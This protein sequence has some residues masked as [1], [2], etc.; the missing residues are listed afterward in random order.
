MP[1]IRRVAHARS[2]AALVCAAALLGAGGAGAQPV[3]AGERARLLA[4]GVVETAVVDALDRADRV[5]VLVVLEG[6]QYETGALAR[7]AAGEDRVRR[8]YGGL[9]A[10][11]VEISGPGLARLA[12]AP[13]VVRV[14]PD[15]RVEA[16]LAQGVPLANLHWL[17]NQGVTG[18]GATVA[19]LDTGIDSDHPN[20]A[21][22]IVAQRCFCDLVPGAGCC[23]NGTATQS[24]AGAAEDDH[25]HG[26]RVA[27]VIRS[28]HASAWGGAPDSS[29]VAVKVLDATGNGMA[30][31][32]LA[33]LDWIL[34]DR[35]DVDVVNM[36]LG[37]GVYAGDCDDAD[38]TTMAFADAVAP[39]HA[40]GTLVVAGSG[41]NNHANAMIMP[42]CVAQVLSVGAV[43][44]ADLGSQTHFVCTDSTTQADQITCWSNQSTT[45]DV[46]APGALTTTTNRGGGLATV[47]GTSYAT[48]LA[49]ACAAALLS[50][51]PGTDADDLTGAL[52]TSRT[53]VSDGG[54]S[55]PRLDCLAALHVLAPPV[56][57][58]PNAGTA[59][60]LLALGLAA[61]GACALRAAGA[62]RQQDR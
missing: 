18:G 27:G 55:Y 13:G 43:W 28:T 36:G 7:L 2:L 51:F 6:R 24:G 23:P 11:A 59:L 3:P 38:A 4:A 61:A 5:P 47:A 34:T 45:T 53:R 31:D 52:R 25:G 16:Q 30:S 10:L 56:P 37:G 50:A 29:I 22:G 8:R 1:L 19:V 35:P 40:R 12:A 44:D 21:A 9:P 58:L 39:L 48:P 20:L 33:G 15:L 42:A 46:F 14:G 41:N 17:H 57:A 62:R 26:T 54:G 49:S 32:I 60:P